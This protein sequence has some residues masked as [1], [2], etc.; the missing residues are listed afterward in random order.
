MI[1]ITR[2]ERGFTIDGHA[3]YAPRGQD[4]VC[5]AVST[6]VAAFCLSVEQLTHDEIK[7]DFKPAH[8]VVE[9]GNLSESGQLLVSSFFV[10]AKM[11]AEE[12]PNNVKI[13][14]A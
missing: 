14:Q 1:V 13:V 6:L 7:A 10:G 11:I 4:I 2:S 8:A 5:A 12:Y 9:Y 3:G